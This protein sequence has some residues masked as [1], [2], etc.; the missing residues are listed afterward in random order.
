MPEINSDV[1]IACSQCAEICPNDAIDIRTKPS[2]PGSTRYLRYC[3]DKK[4]CNNCG[5]CLEVDCPSGA[6]TK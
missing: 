5:K 4:K 2:K 6:L 3:I 1:C